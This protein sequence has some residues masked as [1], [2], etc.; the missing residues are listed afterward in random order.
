[1]TSSGWPRPATRRVLSTEKIDK[2]KAAGIHLVPKGDEVWCISYSKCET[3]LLD[4]IDSGNECRKMCHQLIKR[5]IQIFS[6]KTSASGVSS[7]I[8]KVSIKRAGIRGKKKT[9]K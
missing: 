2:V 3:A 5:Y 6:S 1:M 7:Y 9:A 4:G 8:F